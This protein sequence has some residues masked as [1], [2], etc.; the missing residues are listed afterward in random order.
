[1]RAVVFALATVCLAACGPSTEPQPDPDA[2]AQLGEPE[3]LPRTLPPAG[4]EPR[5]VG[6][7]AAS[8]DMCTDP[9][10]RFRTDGVSTQGEV[11]CTFNQISE[12]AGGYDVQ[13]TCQAEGNTT[14]HQMLDY[15][16][17]ICARDDDCKWTVVS[18]AGT[19]VLR[20]I[21]CRMSRNLC[22]ELRFT[23]RERTV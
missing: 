20:R 10:W 21:I 2:A 9:A 3:V 14:Q 15:L 12:I 8:Q 16:R 17:G 18:V 4:A 19:C 6:L 5:F 1:M 22:A 11:S 13:A 7:W 23:V